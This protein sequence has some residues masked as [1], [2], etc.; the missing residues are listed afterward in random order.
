VFLEPRRPKPRWGLV[1]TEVVGHVTGTPLSSASFPHR[2]PIVPSSFPRRSLVVRK[3]LTIG[4]MSTPEHWSRRFRDT[5]KPS[6][7]P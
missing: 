1:Q 3:K 4:G 6:A 2:S 7:T 5:R